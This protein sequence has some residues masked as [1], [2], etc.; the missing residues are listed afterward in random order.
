MAGK[1]GTRKNKL[2]QEFCR[3]IKRVR[4]TVKV[5]P[6]QPK[7]AAQREAAAIAICVQSVLQT[8]GKTLKRFSCRG[9]NGPTL[10]TQKPLK[11]GAAL[12][13]SHPHTHVNKPK[14]NVAATVANLANNSTNL[15]S[16]FL[17]AIANIF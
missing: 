9:K 13:G 3:C 10:T 5:R 7:T 2:A 8:R 12:V 1:S 4:K 16:G 11:G 15:N 14:T 17:N 6:G